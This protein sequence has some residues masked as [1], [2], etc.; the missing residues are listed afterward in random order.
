MPPSPLLGLRPAAAQ[1]LA[2]LRRRL[3]EERLHDVAEDDR[4]GDLHHGGLEVHREQHVVGLGPRDLLGEELGAA[5]RPHDGAVDDLAGQHRHLLEH[6]G[7]AVVA[8]CSMRSVSS[9]S[10]TTDFSLERKSSA[11]MVATLVLES[12]APGAHRVR[13]LLRVALDRR[14][15]PAV[16]VALAQDRVD[17]GALDLVVARADVLL[18]VGLRVVGVVRQVVAL[19]LQLVD[20]GLQ[21]RDRGG[22]VGQLDD[23]GLGLLGQRAELGER[24]VDP[25][26]VGQP[27]RELRDDP[28]GQG[29]VAGLELHTRL[30]GVRR[31]RSAGRSTSPAAAPRRC[32]CR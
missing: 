25:L 23:V 21:L 13:V 16:G 26:L 18:L 8:D 20:R 29:D 19:L 1:L 31:R 10:M 3:G 11:P 2:V 5:P 14:R 27:L 7:L 28:A 15:R 30:G 12:A 6:L 9:A 22:D 17:R 24:V 32:A 4:V